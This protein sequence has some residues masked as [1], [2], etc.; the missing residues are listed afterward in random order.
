MK[1][2]EISAKTDIRRYYIIKAVF[3]PNEQKVSFQ[4]RIFIY[5]KLIQS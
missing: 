2:C 4:F 5:H 3:Y 1:K